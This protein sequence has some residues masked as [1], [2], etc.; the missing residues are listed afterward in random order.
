MR[1]Y[2]YKIT[3]RDLP[4]YFYYGRHKHR[5][6]LGQYLGSP[7][8]WKCFWGL[9]EP[10]MQ[11]LQWYETLEE[12]IKAENSIIRATWDSPYSL[13]ENCGGRFSEEVCR[14]QGYLNHE[15]A[16]P[17]EMRRANGKAWGEKNAPNLLKYA[18][19]NGSRTGP[20]N[21]KVMNSHPNTIET[22]RRMG[23]LNGPS[24]GRKSLAKMPRETRSKNG[25]NTLVTHGER[26]CKEGAKAANSQKWQSTVDGYIS[27]AGGVANHNRN[28]GWDPKA[29]VKLS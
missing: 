12:A 27:T 1:Y 15:K 6:D 16:F 11:V 8:T 3:F 17:I 5:G 26:I 10:E 4:K 9:F 13:N 19:E 23:A 25:Q 14:E 24:N 28:R 22:N 21:S 20:K 2:T 7:V 18:S 29:R